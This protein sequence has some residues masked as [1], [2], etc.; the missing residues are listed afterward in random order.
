VH[1]EYWIPAAE[2]EEFN[3]NI[4]DLIEI[5]AEFRDSSLG[6]R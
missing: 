2:L 6:D 5:I 3:R 4:V 1:Q